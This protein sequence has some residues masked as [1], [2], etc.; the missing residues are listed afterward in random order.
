MSTDSSDEALMLLY[1]QGQVMAFNT[2]YARH[3]LGVWRYI[4][5]SVQNQGTADELMQDV[6]FAVARAAASY[7][8][9]RNGAKFKTWLFTMAHHRIVDHWRTLKPHAS[10][11]AEGDEADQLRAQLIADSGFGP[12]RQ[13]E[14][15][16]QARALI[17]AVEALPHDQREAFLLQAEGELSVEEIAVTMQVSFETAKS[18]LRYAR[19]KLKT[20]LAQFAVVGA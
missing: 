4:C 8:P 20:L 12:L 5:R 13:I 16:E 18:R 3:E 6:W 19:N 7:E 15:R 17:A 9:E 1:A 14:S 2:L 10:L 11:D